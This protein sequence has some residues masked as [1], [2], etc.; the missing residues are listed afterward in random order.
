MDRLWPY[1]ESYTWFE[2]GLVTLF[3]NYCPVIESIYNPQAEARRAEAISVT[4]HNQE[5]INY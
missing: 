3:T 2:L 5:L 4:S 1:I